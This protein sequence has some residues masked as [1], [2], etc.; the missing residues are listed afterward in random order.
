MVRS[1][2]L[3]EIRRL[4]AEAKNKGYTTKLIANKS[5]LT[6]NKIYY[7]TGAMCER[8]DTDTYD[9]LN[10]FFIKENIR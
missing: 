5:G 7:L 4:I 10:T 9:K 2:H 6:A 3:T 8:I 1:T